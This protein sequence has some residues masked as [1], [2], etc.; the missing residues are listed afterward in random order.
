[1]SDLRKDPVSFNMDPDDYFRALRKGDGSLVSPLSVEPP[2]RS[3]FNAFDCHKPS[4][5]DTFLDHDGPDGSHKRRRSSLS[6]E[7][8]PP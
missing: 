8:P 4:S 2:L 6:Y 3:N 7:A 5:T 1:M